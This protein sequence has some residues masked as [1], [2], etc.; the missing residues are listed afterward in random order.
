MVLITALGVGGATIIG[1]LIGFL[2]KSVSHKFSDIVLSFASGVMLSAAIFGL[3]IPSVELG[4]SCAL[5][6]TVLGIFTGAVFLN[7]CDKAVPHLH[8]LMGAEQEDH[9]NTSL[10]KVILFV[11]ISLRSNKHAL[12][13]DFLYITNLRH[14]VWNISPPKYDVSICSILQYFFYF[15]KMTTIVF[16]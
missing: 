5:L 4:G 8:K 15:I 7:L 16:F 13:I 3:V 11:I 1:A 10:D 14:I 9:T 12:W 2:F 6:I